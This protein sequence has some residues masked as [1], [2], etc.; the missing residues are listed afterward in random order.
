MQELEADACTKAC[1][2]EGGVLLYSNKQEDGNIHLRVVS[3]PL[4]KTL[5]QEILS[6]MIQIY[7]RK[8]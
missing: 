1:L 4:L 3:F 7:N 5:L 8:E 6:D 2:K